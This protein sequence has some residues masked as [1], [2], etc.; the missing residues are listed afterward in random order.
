MAIM[1]LN[2]PEMPSNTG[3]MKEWVVAVVA[4]HC[5]LIFLIIW[6]TQIFL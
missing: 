6:I 2:V 1:L 4:E 3:A 5:C